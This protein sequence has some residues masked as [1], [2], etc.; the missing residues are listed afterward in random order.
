MITHVIVRNIIVGKKSLLRRVIDFVLR[1]KTT[2]TMPYLRFVSKTESTKITPIINLDKA[3]VQ[4]VIELPFP[5]NLKH[6]VPEIMNPNDYPVIVK[7]Q[8]ICLEKRR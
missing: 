5:I 8:F 2:F 7:L 1:R 3:V 6:W 4:P